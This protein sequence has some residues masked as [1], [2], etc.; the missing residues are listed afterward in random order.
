MT[1]RPRR[2]QQQQHESPDANAKSVAGPN[3]NISAV[4][5]KARTIIDNVAVRMPPQHS[6]ADSKARATYF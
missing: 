4:S 1:R 3:S 5:R 2:I 6:A